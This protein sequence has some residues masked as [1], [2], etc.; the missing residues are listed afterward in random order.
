MF[1]LT[2]SSASAHSDY[3]RWIVLRK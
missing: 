3:A 1:K 2:N